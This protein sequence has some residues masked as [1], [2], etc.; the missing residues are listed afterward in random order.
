MFIIFASAPE[1]NKN[2]FQGRVVENLSRINQILFGQSLFG[3]SK[4]S[5]INQILSLGGCISFVVF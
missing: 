3:L 1:S 4:R 5:G 2:Q